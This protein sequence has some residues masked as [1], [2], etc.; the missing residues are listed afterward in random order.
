MKKVLIF[1]YYWPPAG[2]VAVQRFLKFSK[3]LP[4][5]GWQ[6]IIITV[7]NGSYPFA[8]DSLAEQVHPVTQVYRTNTFEP[9]ELYNLLQGKKGKS[10][11]TVSVGSQQQQSWF[12][13]FSEYIRANF[14]IPDARKGWVKYAVTEAEKIISKEKIDAII[15]TGPPHSTH[16][17]GLQLK[18]KFDL[19]WMADFR[20]PWTNNLMNEFLPRTSNT[21]KKD[22]ALET[23][24]LNHAD[25]VSV[26]SEGMKDEFIERAKRVS[27]IYNGFD[28]AD[29]NVAPKASAPYFSLRHVGN[30]IVS[31]NVPALWQ[32]ISELLQEQ[33][34]FKEK[35]R[36]EI[37][38]GIHP[39]IQESFKQANIQSNIT[40]IGH[41]PHNVAIAYMKGASC[42]LF[43]ISDVAKSELLM[44]GKI[45]EYIA[46]K[47]SILP[48]GPIHGNA[49]Q[50]LNRCKRD[51]MIAFTDKE[52][53]K[54]TL[55]NHFNNWQKTQTEFEYSGQ[56]H[57]LYS[58]QQQCGELAQLLNQL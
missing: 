56:E 32:A 11:P 4:E 53:M 54:Q 1:T 47:R 39:S 15:T 50:L 25:A 9:F 30:L 35:F 43:L 41:V 31:M 6:P 49:A 58:R 57:L 28:D 45:F 2:G 36:L 40:Y 5:Y 29:F 17:I 38:G 10:L 8:D 27:V 52:K 7:K 34:N 42:L 22:L 13:K 14:F 48:I 16:L 3:Y 12:Q 51:E 24:V 55:L 26:I 33:A 18:K 19:Q 46:A 20:D 21:I 37:I 23:D 44:S